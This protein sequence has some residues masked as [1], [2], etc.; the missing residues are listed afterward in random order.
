MFEFLDVISE[1]L[2][3]G[4]Q[5]LW[6]IF[7]ATLFLWGFI[8]ERILYFKFSAPPMM[9]KCIHLW[10]KRKDKTSYFSHQAREVLV[11]Q[12]AS[13]L[14][15]NIDTIQVIVAICPMLGLLGTVTGMIAVFDVM[16]SIGTGNARLMAS[17]IS[18]ATIP[19]M[20]GMVASLS[21]FFFAEHLQSRQRRMK[22]KLLD[23]LT[24]EN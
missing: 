22:E 16:A 7:F 4:G 19:T 6:A 2:S 13:H 1:F 21:G 24:F 15:K 18:K 12:F 5:V 20:A 9:K 11:S 8:I 10:K 23:Q 14:K 3:R 17:G